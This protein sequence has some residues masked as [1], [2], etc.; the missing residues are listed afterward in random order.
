M[1]KL[2]T[3]LLAAL[4]IGTAS[5]RELT[6][7]MGDSPIANGST[8]AYS[9]VTVKDLGDGWKEVKMEPKLYLWSDIVTN[10]VKVTAACATGQTIQM[11][12]GGQC[13]FGATVVK[14]NVSIPTRSKLDLQFEYYVAEMQ[15]EVPTLTVN[16]DAE[17]M[18]YGTKTAFTLVMG[19]NASAGIKDL[20]KEKEIWVT[21]AGIEYNLQAPAAISLYSITGTQVLAVKASGRGTVNT[22]SLHPGIYI[23]TVTTSAG[24]TTGKIHVR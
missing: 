22:H 11:C 21:P 1:K 2:Y 20:A 3:L 5:A 14:Q 4:A 17:D 8:V 10:T 6:F 19:P 16:F 15:G 23:Y 7:Y 24:R 12:A 18:S 9:D 13:E